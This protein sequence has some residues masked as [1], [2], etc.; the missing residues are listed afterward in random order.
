MNGA[1]IVH[2]QV[3]L[4]GW[5]A[6]NL[7]GNI[8]AIDDVCEQIITCVDQ[9]VV[10]SVAGHAGAGGVML[11]LWADQRPPGRWTSTP[12]SATANRWASA[13]S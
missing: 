12:G 11:A 7:L 8:H 13:T 10:C 9:L 2:D 4:A 1:R 6:R 3:E 5:Q